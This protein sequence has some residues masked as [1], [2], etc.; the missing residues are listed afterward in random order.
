[1]MMMIEFLGN[2]SEIEAS[3]KGYRKIE[4]TRDREF[5]S[6]STQHCKTSSRDHGPNLFC[7]FQW[8]WIG[9]RIQTFPLSSSYVMFL[10]FFS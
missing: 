3:M 10:L 6:I 1:M 7:L 9:F 2:E 4:F 8:I 5:S